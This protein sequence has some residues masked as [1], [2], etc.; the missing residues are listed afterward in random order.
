MGRRRL[1]AIMLSGFG[2]EVHLDLGLGCEDVCGGR[3]GRVLLGG[4]SWGI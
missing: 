4:G 1:R 3:L 2:R